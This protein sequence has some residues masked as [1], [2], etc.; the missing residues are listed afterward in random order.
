MYCSFPTHQLTP[1]LQLEERPLPLGGESLS[2]E[3]WKDV[4]VHAAGPSELNHDGG[5]P[6]VN[7]LFRVS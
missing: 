7:A 3:R 1:V 6:S 2:F 5:E 4:I